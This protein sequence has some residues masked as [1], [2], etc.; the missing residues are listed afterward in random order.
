MAASVRFIRA[1]Y[2]GDRAAAA[3]RMGQTPCH[4]SGNALGVGVLLLRANCPSRNSHCSRM[5]VAKKLLAG[6]VK[7]CRRSHS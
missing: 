7:V 6:E 1:F 2:A 3:R 5:T 4:V